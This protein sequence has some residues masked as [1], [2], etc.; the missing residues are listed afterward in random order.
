MSSYAADLAAIFSAPYES[1]EMEDPETTISQGSPIVKEEDREPLMAS[2]PQIKPPSINTES[3]LSKEFTPNRSDYQSIEEGVASS[4]AGTTEFRSHDQLGRISRWREQM[5]QY[6]NYSIL[7]FKDDYRVEREVETVV[8]VPT[9]P[10]PSDGAASS[11]KASPTL[12]IAVNPLNAMAN[13]IAEAFKKR[14]PTGSHSSFLVSSAMGCKSETSLKYTPLTFDDEEQLPI[15]G[16]MGNA[17]LN[18][19]NNN[20][21]AA[22][23]HEDQVANSGHTAYGAAF[24]QGGHR[25]SGRSGPFVDRISFRS[26]LSVF[27]IC[28]CILLVFFGIICISAIGKKAKRSHADH[29]AALKHREHHPSASHASSHLSSDEN[30]HRIS[31]EKH[32]QHLD[33]HKRVNQRSSPTGRSSFQEKR[34]GAVPQVSALFKSRSDEKASKLF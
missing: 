25:E 26:P 9:T 21:S 17:N 3:T 30:A 4:D 10:S 16:G 12:N 6:I 27:T 20:S 2:T 19:N 33:N 13:S 15:C 32:G 34:K 22:T 5:H 31:N 29:T 1:T 18:S 14:S 23:N 8:D 7:V 24:N 11:S 28:L